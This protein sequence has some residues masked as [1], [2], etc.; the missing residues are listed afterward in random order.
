MA[1]GT[2][3]YNPTKIRRSMALKATLF[4][5]HK[6]FEGH[7]LGADLKWGVSLSTLAA[8]VVAR[9]ALGPLL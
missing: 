5:I 7:G 3:R 6:T 4:G 1:F 8:S 2:K 9:T